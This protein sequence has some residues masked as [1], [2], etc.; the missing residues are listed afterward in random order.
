MDNRYKKRKKRKGVKEVVLLP[1]SIAA[2]IAA[3]VLE[4]PTVESETE[5][6]APA[7]KEGE[8]DTGITF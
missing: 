1:L 4:V 7:D 8:H 6:A 5:T 2:L 3:L